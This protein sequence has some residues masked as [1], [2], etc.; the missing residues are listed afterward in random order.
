[1]SWM[2]F[3]FGCDI[4]KFLPNSNEKLDTSNGFSSCENTTGLSISMGFDV[5]VDVV[6]VVVN[7]IS[8]CK[9]NGNAVQLIK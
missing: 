4:F 8:D 3:G 6:V 7:I 5:V 1:M 9:D 2:E